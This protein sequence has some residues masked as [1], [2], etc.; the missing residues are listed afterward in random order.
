MREIAVLTILGMGLVTYATRASGLVLGR[1][2]HMPDWFDDLIEALPGAILVS[3]I[4]PAIIAAGVK[5][6]IAA[7]ATVATALLLKGNIII[8]MLL[9]I[10]VI[11]GLRHLPT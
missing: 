7:A 6:L 9:G 2:L 4:A 5:G 10:L 3:L 1:N 11:T 8:P